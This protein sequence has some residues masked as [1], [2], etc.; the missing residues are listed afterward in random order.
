MMRDNQA[1]MAES[2]SRPRTPGLVYTALSMGLF[3][4]ISTIALTTRQP[5]PPS[6]SEFAPQS[7]EQITE[8]PEEQGSGFGEGAGEG[9]L[10]ALSPETLAAQQQPPIDVPRVRKCIGDPP[11][12][13]EDPQSPPCVP[14]FDG[15]NGG[16]TSQG[17]T[18]NE[19]SVAFPN[20]NFLVD[21]RAIAD[22]V[23]HFN[24][25][26]EF[27]GRKIFL[28]DYAPRGGFAAAP[29]PPQMFAD[30]VYVDE[31]V[32]AFASI[33]YPARYGAEYHYYD[34]LARRGVVSVAHRPQLVDEAHYRE[35]APY[36]W[37]FLPSTELMLRNYGEFVCN[38]L[39][40]KRPDYAGPEISLRSV[41]KFGLIYQ[42]LQDGSAPDVSP[43]V[44]TMTACGATPV[45]VEDSQKDSTQ[46]RQN[47]VVTLNS[48]NVTSVI[49]WCDLGDT[50]NVHMPGAS[51]Q[52]FLPEWLLSTYIDQDLDNS[53]QGNNAEHQDH[54]LG[55]SFR[56]KFLP[57]FD[58]PWYWAVREVDNSHDP[59]GGNYYHLQARYSS[60]LLLASGIQMAGPKLTPATFQQG[61]MRARFPNPAAGASPYYQGRA[62]FEGN[63]HTMLSD[64]VMFW[65]S[66]SQPGVVDPSFPGRVCYILGGQRFGLGRWPKIDAPFQEECS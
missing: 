32:Q 56:N 23:L 15:D 59:Q 22:M 48:Q 6:I 61:L 9:E 64:G 35:Q 26:Y 52:G 1:A 36:Q 50:R 66:G 24:S 16:S 49:C 19:I 40:G 17:V 58:M 21:N 29:D 60:L 4:L 44:N 25:R 62:G 57:K 53:F 31:E 54:V 43:L 45:V 12:Q 47:G 37:H 63:R 3:I 13:S 33:G 20:D 2:G 65:Y 55:V 8:A 42:R 10:G 14:Y 30:A 28:A 7:V 11:R 51:N 46:V 34:E 5:P 38:V 41:R 27:Y 39:A 18:R